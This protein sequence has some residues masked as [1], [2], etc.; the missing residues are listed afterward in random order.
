MRRKCKCT[1]TG[2]IGYTDEFIKIK[3]K[4]YKS[5]EVYDE[6]Q[7]PKTL[8]RKIVDH[9]CYEFLNYEKGQKFNTILT[10]K[11]NELNFYSNEVILETIEQQDE[12]IKK[13]LRQKD[14]ENESLKIAYIFG[15]INN[16]INQVY[17]DKKRVKS[18]QNSEMKI[19]CIDTA[20]DMAD[21]NNN[22]NQ[23]DRKDISKFLGDDEV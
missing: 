11:L 2:E 22:N 3:N 14:F 6:F 20:R 1:I 19:I 5:Q 8:Y 17:E 16:N 15:I 7:K 23:K 4:Y 18:R 12:K 13:A 10:R 21:I 9:I